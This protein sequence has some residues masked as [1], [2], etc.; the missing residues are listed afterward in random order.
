MNIS[1][2]YRTVLL[3]ALLCAPL[4]VEA[5][6][7]TSFTVVNADTGADIGT[8]TSA[9]TVSVLGNPNINVRA[10][11]KD[12]TKVVFTDA[13]G[14]TRTENFAPYS[15]KGD[16]SGVYYKWT[17]TAGNY[18]ITA[19]PFSGNGNAGAAA[20]ITLTITNGATPTPTPAATVTSFTVVNAD[21]GADIGTFTSAG[22][23]SLLGNPN[24]NVRA[25]TMDT[26]KVIF[27]DATGN[28]RTEN[29]APY[30]YKGDTAGVYY[31][32]TPT[33]GDY[34]INAMP[35][36][37][38][39]KAGAV[40]TFTLTII[41][42][43]TPPPV[44]RSTPTV[45]AHT[46]TK[47][48]GPP[49]NPHKGWNSGNDY[50][51][52][53]AT[54]GGQ[55]LKW[56]DFEP[57][58]GEFNFNVVEEVLNKE[59]T[60]GKHFTL[61][62]FCD[63]DANDPTPA[64][65]TWLYSEG[66]KKI[67]GA[68]KTS[69]T[70]YNDPIFVKEA[71]KAIEALGSRY[72]G[73]PRVHAFQ[74]GFLGFWGEWHSVWFHYPDGTGYTIALETQNAIINAFKKYFPKSNLQGRYPW[75]EPLKST[76]GIGFHN[77]AFV[78]NTEHSDEFDKA[79][80]DGGQWKNG[81][82]GGETPPRSATERAADMIAMHTTPKGPSMIATGH[83]STMAG[84]YKEPM[85]DPY[86]ESSMRLNKMM[87]YNFQIASANFADTVS[88][89]DTM[90]I[91][92]MASNIGVAPTYHAWQVQFALLNGKDEP[93]VQAPADFRLATVLPG[94]SFSLSANLLPGS[95]TPGNYRLA[96][97]VIQTD[98]DL[99][100]ASPWKLDARNTYILFANDLPIVDGSWR[101]DNA[102]QGGWS[103]LGSISLH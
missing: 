35:F 87:G 19:L 30:S 23:V 40:A 96:V 28:I 79:L 83:Y 55:Y 61:R 94:T 86:Y 44:A 1:T 6:T 8:F 97:R 43:P 60:R 51:D 84:G 13:T 31:K 52:N 85:G 71:V 25:N 5:Q 48:D 33:A 62:V 103:V 14:S 27:T 15:Y 63:W 81:P 37:S 22:T 98:A 69:I 101:A 78:P 95:V 3:G 66:V 36:S 72:D 11:T 24:I 42:G 56:K 49:K 10:N 50:A 34:V 18:V 92:L 45:V 4:C 12:T 16:T 90:S 73:D 65:P 20:T 26:T 70:D 80:R 64:G 39:G 2:A 47:N 75:R 82:I 7:V 76:G 77:D 21:T 53:D 102:L 89:T 68:D 46:Y 38:K 54:V 57:N 17:P 91:Q 58:A 9:G 41:P 29:F 88:T 59:G 93:V 32:W 67:I 100:K 99:A 74:L